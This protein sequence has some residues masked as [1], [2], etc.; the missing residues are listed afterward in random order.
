M[1][2]SS[3][4]EV[5]DDA[6]N[7]AVLQAAY[8][9]YVQAVACSKALAQAAREGY[10]VDLSQARPHVESIIDCLQR[11]SSALV[12]ILKLKSHGEYAHTHSVNVCVYALIFGRRLGQGEE[13]LIDLGMG[14]LL[15]DIGNATL[16]LSILEKPGRLT[17]E[18]YRV[19]MTHPAAGFRLLAAGGALSADV[20]R[21]VL[22]HHERYQGQ[23]YPKGLS[24][25]MI[26]PLARIISIC[27]VYDAMT[28]DRCYH[29]AMTPAEVLAKMYAWKTRDFD[30]EYVDLFIK[31]V[32]IY[33]EGSFVRLKDGRVGMVVRNNPD[34]LLYPQIRV[35]IHSDGAIIRPRLLNLADR[36]GEVSARIVGAFDPKEYG[37]DVGETLGI[38]L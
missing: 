17:P 20:G 27:D 26:S 2:S 14:A 30:P 28:S 5:L 23:G 19:V 38:S 9:V 16:P 18:E 21:A 4:G 37:L 12:S 32:G 11:D 33:P 31:C 6:P 3:T 7:S 29:R 22:E 34:H 10:G 35:F 13:S 24:G 1:T 15:H 36:R 8:N 25:D